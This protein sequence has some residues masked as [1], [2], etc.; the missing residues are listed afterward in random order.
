MEKEAYLICL[1][2][3]DDS[4]GYLHFNAK[5]NS[6]IVGKTKIGAC[7]FTKENA[8]E[9]IENGNM[10]NATIEKLDL[11]KTKFIKGQYDEQGNVI[12]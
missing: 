9:M 8:L 11:S 10:T 12:I 6:Y 3:S 4:I 1:K 7:G 2:L 5:I